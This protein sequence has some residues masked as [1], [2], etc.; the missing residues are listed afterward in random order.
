MHHQSAL[1]LPLYIIAPPRGDH[2]FHDK[3][4]LFYKKGEFI[5]FNYNL[6]VF[7]L[8]DHNYFVSWRPTAEK[9]RGRRRR[10]Q[11]EYPQ[12]EGKCLRCVTRNPIRKSSRSALAE[13]N[14]ILAHGRLSRRGR[15]GHFD[16]VRDVHA[17]LACQMVRYRGSMVNYFRLCHVF[18]RYCNFT[19]TKEWNRRTRRVG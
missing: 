3:V 5:E 11:I 6:H 2:Q 14:R 9:R 18:V 19:K 1:F 10:K 16:R 7:R 17:N 15:E 12:G 4:Q 8:V 13:Q